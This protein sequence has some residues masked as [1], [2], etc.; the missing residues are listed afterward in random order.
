MPTFTASTLPPPDS[1]DEFESICKSAF[2]LRWANPNLARHGRL[3]QK[4]DGVDIYGVDPLQNLV[5]VQC[6]NTTKS[7]STDLIESE[8]AKAED[9][10]PGL[11]ALYI[12]TTTH[13]DANIQAFARKLSESR[14][15]QN[16]FPV[17]VVFWPDVIHDLSREESAIRQHYPQYFT[18]LTKTPDQLKREADIQNLTSILEVVD[19]NSTFDHL[20]WGAKY[21][22]SSILDQI[23]NIDRV[24]SYPSF[25]IHDKPLL[26]AI[27]SLTKNW[28]NLCQLIR[29]APY[30]LN[31]NEILRFNMP[32]DFCR[33]EQENEL[34]EEIDTKIEALI[35]SIRLFCSLINTNYL[36]ISIEA[37]SRKARSLY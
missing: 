3:G 17:D 29:I 18:H 32:G 24:L 31:Q 22:H 2:S 21:I 10:K 15:A 11:S 4:Q 14:K 19:F 9:F 23:N 6:K 20:K 37:T 12:A 7:I 8:C 27:N 30:D 26:E 36:E 13:R 16:K 34:Y 28:R 1:W 25:N 35:H 33:N 5:G